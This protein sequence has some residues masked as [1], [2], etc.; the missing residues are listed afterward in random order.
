MKFIS[1][2]W[3][4]SDGSFGNSFTSLF[5]LDHVELWL[6]EKIVFS[7]THKGKLQKKLNCTTFD[8]TKSWKNAIRETTWD[9]AVFPVFLIQCNRLGANMEVG[10]F[11]EVF[12][13]C[14]QTALHYN[15]R[16]IK[17][18]S[19]LVHDT[20]CWV[21]D[22]F[23]N[24]SDLFANFAKFPLSFKRFFFSSPNQNLGF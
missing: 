7:W 18:C 9:V 3:R 20:F 11:V 17:K 1:K 21:L 15:H 19:Q 23:S 8:S 13:S 5:D 6:P 14:S 22:F 2:P 24:S 10:Q 4:S 12:G 16:E